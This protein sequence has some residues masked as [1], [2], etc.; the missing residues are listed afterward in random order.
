MRERNQ[1]A[2]C[3]GGMA[4]AW[5]VGDA[6]GYA[7]RRSLQC[8]RGPTLPH[9]LHASPPLPLPSPLQRGDRPPRPSPTFET[10]WETHFRNPARLATL[11]FHAAVTSCMLYVGAI[12]ILQFP[13]G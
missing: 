10:V 8:A 3:V 9:P 6:H 1:G 4:R 12:G 11:L 7:G 13:G 2:T 5:L